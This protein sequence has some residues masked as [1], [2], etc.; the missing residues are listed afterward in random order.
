MPRRERANG[1]QWSR[2][3]IK[4]NSPWFP[5]RWRQVKCTSELAGG[6]DTAHRL[7][8]EGSLGACRHDWAKEIFFFFWENWGGVGLGA[9][10]RSRK[11]GGQIG[12]QKINFGNLQSEGVGQE[13]RE[14]GK[15]LREG[16]GES[17]N[18]DN[19]THD[20]QTLRVTRLQGAQGR[21]RGVVAGGPR[22]DRA[23]SGRSIGVPEL[24]GGDSQ[25]P[26]DAARRGRCL[27]LRRRR[28]SWEV[29]NVGFG[30]PV[31]WQSYPRSSNDSKMSVSMRSHSMLL[32]Y[33]NFRVVRLPSSPATRTLAHALLLR[34]FQVNS[35]RL[36]RCTAHAWSVRK[37]L[38]SACRPAPAG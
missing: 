5:R 11:F 18:P 38:G 32:W 13:D 31:H 23:G 10:N 36:S 14:Q 34:N 7:V 30:R 2:V 3:R 25:E 35:W 27:W 19:D 29:C 12:K 33:S 20:W 26:R 16:G 24:Q 6:T 37:K 28:S 22:P 1:A 21:P 17:Q 9:Q 4:G 15:E 8:A